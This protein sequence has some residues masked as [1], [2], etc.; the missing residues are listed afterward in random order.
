MAKCGWHLIASFVSQRFELSAAVRG[1]LASLRRRIGPS[2]LP[3]TWHRR[4]VTRCLPCFVLP[5]GRTGAKNT[6]GT[7]MLTSRNG[8][9]LKT[10][11]A[12]CVGWNYSTRTSEVRAVLALPSLEMRLTYPKNMPIV[13]GPIANL[14]TIRAARESC[15]VPRRIPRT[16]GPYCKKNRLFSSP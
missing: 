3:P 7:Q 1:V 10:T 12:A 9:G 16:R 4:T 2:A 15:L 6:S 13:R 11:G 14:S 5:A 8:T